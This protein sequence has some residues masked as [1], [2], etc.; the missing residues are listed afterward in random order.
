LH[1]RA[2]ATSAAPSYFPAK[3]IRGLGFLQDGGAGKHN[4]PIDPAEW[5][6]RAIWDAVPDVAL[7]IG[8]GYARDP[9]S[10]QIVSQRL[11][12]RD[13]FFA[14]LARLFN[15]V[16][17]AQG[18]WDDHMNRTKPSDKHKYFRINIALDKEPPLDD[19]G[20][21]PEMENSAR[22]FLK[23]YDLSNITQALFAA[24]FFFEL[25]SKPSTG[26]RSC[27]CHGTIRCRSPDTRALIKRI[28]EEYPAASFT[29]EDGTNLGFMNNRALCATCGLYCQAVTFKVCH[30]NH[31]MSIFLKFNRLSQHRISGFPDAMSQFSRR[32][33][34]GA[35]FGR[36]DHRVNDYTG[37]RCTASRKRKRAAATAVRSNKRQCL[38]FAIQSV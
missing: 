4:N 31:S 22:T 6:S 37:C 2:R 9:D 12:F 33:L 27:R 28:F 1:V 8:T 13:R 10:P 35:E 24:S 25:H 18:S 26:R 5:E 38:S 20:G 3:F 19:V 14:R 15:A 23:A 11:P 34:L 36:P 32:Q 29:T 7:S 17:S 16:L 30:F 21:I